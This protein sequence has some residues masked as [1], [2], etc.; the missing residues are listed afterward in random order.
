MIGLQLVEFLRDGCLA[1]QL[2]QIG[3]EFA[4]DVFDAHQVFARVLQA[5]F[6]FAAAFLVLRDAGRFFQEDAQFF[7]TG[8]DDARDHALADDRV[9]ARAEAG[10]EEDVLNVAAAH[11]LVVDVV[12]S[13]CRRA[14]AR[15]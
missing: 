10:A 9:G 8:F 1:L 11:R 2:F 12:A 13:R 4:Q 5:V 3:I 7:G 6:G 15:A 14:S